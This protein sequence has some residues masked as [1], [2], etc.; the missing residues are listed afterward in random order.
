[1]RNVRT[2]DTKVN[3][4]PNNMVIEVWILARITISSTKLKVELH[5]SLSN[6]MICEPITITDI[7]NVLL[8]G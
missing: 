3:K 7:L 6:Q 1:M 2:S 5:R 8:L 4:V